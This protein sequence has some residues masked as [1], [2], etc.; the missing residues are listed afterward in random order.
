MLCEVIFSIIPVSLGYAQKSSKRFSL[1]EP[2]HLLERVGRHFS[3]YS[4]V[5]D[6]F[7]VPFMVLYLEGNK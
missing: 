7:V 2:F 1:V 4:C 5:E 6:S 3:W